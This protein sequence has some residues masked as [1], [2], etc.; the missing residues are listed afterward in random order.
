LRQLWPSRRKK[1]VAFRL[2]RNN[3]PPVTDHGYVAGILPRR[4][5]LVSKGIIISVLRLLQKHNHSRTPRDLYTSTRAKA[6]QA[7]RGGSATQTQSG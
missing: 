5:E 2:N 1:R 4:S 6:N 3:V 7:I